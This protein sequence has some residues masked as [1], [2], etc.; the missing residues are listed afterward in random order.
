MD[1]AR[2]VTRRRKKRSRLGFTTRVAA[3]QRPFQTGSSTSGHEAQPPCGRSSL[4]NPGV[5]DS[6][7]CSDRVSVVFRR[8]PTGH[9]QLGPLT[10]GARA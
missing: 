1:Q 3:A 8:V 2:A 4:L 7:G 5:A 9:G 6:H 10:S